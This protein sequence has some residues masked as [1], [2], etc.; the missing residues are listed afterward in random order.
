MLENRVRGS[1]G[2]NRELAVLQDAL[3]G[4][5]FLFCL[6]FFGVPLGFRIGLMAGIDGVS[7]IGGGDQDTH[8]GE[9]KQL[10]EG[11]L[12]GLRH[13]LNKIP[14]ISPFYNSIL[15]HKILF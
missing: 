3:V 8:C 10:S 13:T 7:G 11:R 4:G 15:L 2:D 6:L 5:T 9:W 14:L 12:I 1:E